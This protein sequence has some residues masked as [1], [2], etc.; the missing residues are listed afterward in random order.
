M[1][2]S[3]AAPQPPPPHL[4]DNVSFLDVAV[5]GSQAL[6]GDVLHKD[7]AGQAQAIFC[8]QIERQQQR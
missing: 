4:Q 3:R 1:K 7:V 6:R 2:K 8:L 5:S